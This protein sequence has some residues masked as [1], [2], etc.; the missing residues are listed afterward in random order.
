MRFFG[1]PRKLPSIVSGLTL[2]T[3]TEQIDSS[4]LEHPVHGAQKLYCIGTKDF[5]SGR[6]G[7]SCVLKHR[8]CCTH[9][10]VPLWG[11]PG[12][13]FE[14]EGFLSIAR[15]WY[16]EIQINRFP[17]WCRFKLLFFR[18]TGERLKRR[19]TCRDGVGDIVE[20][21]GTYKS[22]VFNRAISIPLGEFEFS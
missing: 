13:W 7:L 18:G 12:F 14:G 15:H 17:L 6:F 10:I 9:W 11:C 20:I 19:M 8:Y 3:I 16:D 2:I 22:L 4:R 1:K 21:A 5:G